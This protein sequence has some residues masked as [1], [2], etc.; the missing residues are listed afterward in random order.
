MSIFLLVVSIFPYVDKSV[1]VLINVLN[2]LF[3]PSSL[4]PHPSQYRPTDEALQEC[5]PYGAGH[6][7]AMHPMLRTHIAVVESPSRIDSNPNLHRQIVVRRLEPIRTSLR[8]SGAGWAA[9]VKLRSRQGEANLG[10]RK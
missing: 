6:L 2:F 3:L 10:Q 9:A 7:G 1:G 4:P 5:F 8:N